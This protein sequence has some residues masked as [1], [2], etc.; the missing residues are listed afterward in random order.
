MFISCKTDPSGGQD[1]GQGFLVYRR[2]QRGG[3]PG[4]GEKA[5]LHQHGRPGRVGHQVDIVSGRCGA[6]PVGRREDVVQQLLKLPGQ[7]RGGFISGIERLRTAGLGRGIGI[8]VDGQQKSVR[9]TVYQTEA[10]R[11]SQRLCL[12]MERSSSG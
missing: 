5:A 12:A 2:L 8:L 6:S 4:I 7:R 3:L 11:V 1:H 10:C 9:R